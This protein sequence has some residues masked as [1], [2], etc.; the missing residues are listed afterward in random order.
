[1]LLDD[2]VMIAES[3]LIYTTVL[4]GVG[5]NQDIHQEDFRDKE[6]LILGGG[7]GG[8]LCELLKEKPKFVTMAEI[9]DDVIKVCKK[10]L[11]GVCYDAL[12]QYDGVNHR[13]VLE[14]CVKVLK[15]FASRGK[16]VDFVINDLTEYPVEKSV[17]GHHYDFTTSNMILELSLEVL[18]PEG[19]KFLARGNCAS[20]SDFHARFEADVTA[21][22]LEFHARKV[23]VPSFMEEYLLYEVFRPK[24]PRNGH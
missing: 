13:I 18:R 10:H 23:Y 15:D 4:C 5:T 2:D 1:L 16:K 14:D 20:A 22:G 6:V 24:P 19:G 11:R 21:L 3:D 12:D 9:D 17:H 8:I 7:D